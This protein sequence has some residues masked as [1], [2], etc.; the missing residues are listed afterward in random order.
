MIQAHWPRRCSLLVAL[1]PSLLLLPGAAC[2][3]AKDRDQGLLSSR[4]YKG[5]ESDLDA[6]NLVTAYPAL[7]GTR[8]DDCQTCHKGDTFS[9]D[10]SGQIREVYVNACD[11]CHL[12]QHPG[13]A[14]FI[15]PTPTTYAE[16]LN[17]YGL[18]YKNAGRNRGAPLQIADRDS[19]GDGHSNATE[20]ADLKY[21]GD[22]GSMPGQPV[23]PNRIYTRAALQ[24]LPQ[25]TEFL[26]C[27][28][29][30]QQFDNYAQYTGV[31][32]RDLLQ[33]AGVNL[34][35]TAITGLS[36]IAPD[37]YVTTFSIDDVKRQYP[38]GIYHAGLDNLGNAECNFVT[39]PDQLPTGLI[40]GAAI[41]DAQWLLLAHQ[42]EGEA[43]QPVNLDPSSG[44]INGEGPLRAVVPQSTAGGPDR[45]SSYSP[46]TCNDGWDYD[47]SKDHN[48]GAM[49]RG[50]VAIR[51]D[52]LPE[53]VEDFDAKNDGWALIYQDAVVVY[54][55]GVVP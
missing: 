32:V 34:D 21:P 7:L 36:M 6:N 25:H 24:A 8:L 31:R 54:G 9:Y 11:Y 53:G 15:E 20:I 12:I 17:P 41:P 50:V 40:D 14:I 19:D 44:R 45:G 18:D 42:R 23:A 3:T 26:L 47:A 52:P 39:Y 2:D 38:D 49:V 51:V 33:D 22:P 5:H 28:S 16:T 43:M 35:D 4:S 30:R 37:G 27:N 55:H 10:S 29:N 46:T 1:L 13:T 48:A